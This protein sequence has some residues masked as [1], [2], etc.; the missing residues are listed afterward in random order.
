MKKDTDE[1]VKAMETARRTA[2]E[3]KISTDEMKI[4]LA[5]KKEKIRTTQKE[6]ELKKINSVTDKIHLVKRSRFSQIYALR[7]QTQVPLS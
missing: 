5:D 1:I 2:Y 3:R 6:H 4:S 7:Q